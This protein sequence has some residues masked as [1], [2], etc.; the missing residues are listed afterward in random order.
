MFK[1]DEIFNVSNVGIVACGFLS[2]GVIREGD[3]LLIGPD[4]DG[5]FR[6]VFV[7]S[8]QR[9]RTPCRLVQAGQSAAVAL[10]DFNEFPIR[11]VMKIYS[12]Y[13]C[14]V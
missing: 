3:E 14:C 9:N 13:M 10:G 1:I 12:N 4:I 7:D 11:K 6:T 2:K 5:S 8:L